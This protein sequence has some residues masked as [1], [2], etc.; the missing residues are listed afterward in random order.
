[1]RFELLYPSDG[2]R[3]AASVERSNIQHTEVFERKLPGVLER[4]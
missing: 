3:S 1:M 2:K 4:S